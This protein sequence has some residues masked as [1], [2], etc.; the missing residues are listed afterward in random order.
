MLLSYAHRMTPLHSLKSQL[1]ISQETYLHHSIEPRHACTTE[2]HTVQSYMHS[3]KEKPENF[4]PILLG[5][6]FGKHKTYKGLSINDVT[7]L[8]GG[9]SAQK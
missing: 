8:G 2:K 3:K 4:C 9:G 5:V 1:L 7:F 6:I